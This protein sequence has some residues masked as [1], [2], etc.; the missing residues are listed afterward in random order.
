MRFLRSDQTGFNGDKMTCIQFTSKV[1][2]IKR[3]AFFVALTFGCAVSHAEDASI[4][5]ATNAPTPIHVR[6]LLG[7]EGVGKKVGGTLMIEGDSLK[8]RVK[9]EPAPICL[10]LASIQN[11]DV[12]SEDRQIGGVP[13][14]LGK[15]AVP[16][17]GGRALS[18]VSRKKFDTLTLGYTDPN[19]GYHGAVFELEKGKAQSVRSQLLVDGVLPGNAVTATQTEGAQGS[20]TA[21]SRRGRWNV[22]VG[23]V[24]VDDDTRLEPAFRIAIYEN[25]LKEVARTNAFGEVFR[26]GDR[27][28]TN[29]SDL[30]ILKTTVSNY[31]PGSET[32]RSVTTVAGATKIR[33]RMQLFTQAGQLLTDREVS[34]NV[35]FFGDNLKATNNLAHNLAKAMKHIAADNS[36][37]AGAL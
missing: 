12:G 22:Q 31:S 33:V 28:A 24:D 11:A 9:G 23:T 8:F 16:F 21:S 37:G 27:N 34:G 17:G 36:L 30:L 7:F 4:A 5:T 18:L 15:A 32:L 13:M 14:A 10:R 3:I 6:H 1:S 29:A 20:T 35:R 19:G 25:L 2:L 26:S